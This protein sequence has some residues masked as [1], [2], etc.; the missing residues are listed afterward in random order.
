MQHHRLQAALGAAV[1][2]VV[3]LGAAPTLAAPITGTPNDDILPGTPGRDTIRGL[4]GNDTI[5]PGKNVDRAFGDEGDDTFVWAKGDGQDRF[6]GGPEIDSYP[7]DRL[8]I[9][10]GALQRLHIDALGA[11][12]MIVARSGLEAVAVQGLEQIEIRRTDDADTLVISSDKGILSPQQ[13]C[14]PNRLVVFGGAGEIDASK[15][16]APTKL[17]TRRSDGSTGTVVR[18]SA[19]F[20]DQ[21]YTGPAD[22]KIRTGAGGSEIHSDPGLDDIRL[23]EGP[24]DVWEWPNDLGHDT[25]RGFGANDR[26]VL[27]DVFYDVHLLDTNGDSR[28]DREDGTVKVRDGSM[29]IDL[30]VIPG[31]SG[32]MVTLI[33]RTR[34]GMDRIGVEGEE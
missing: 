30:S 18:D 12:P 1:S 5:T 26:I 27:Y 6:D 9:T 29:T 15:V 19:K 13:G 10:A 32:V 14:C 24:D 34:I 16:Q 3:L 20:H 8:E 28:L 22:D 31:Y 7:G 17:S 2:L 25:V 33:G 4:A 21:I 11:G 23:G